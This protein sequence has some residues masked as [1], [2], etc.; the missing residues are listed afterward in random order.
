MIFLSPN[1]QV[2]GKIL[3]FE[4]VSVSLDSA[5]V[6]WE[7]GDGLRSL[8][9]V[10][11]PLRVNYYTVTPVENP[12]TTSLQLTGLS[13]YTSYQVM[14]RGVAGSRDN[15]STV[16]TSSLVF[17]TALQLDTNHM[18][19]VSLKDLVLVLLLL[20]LWLLVIMLFLHRWG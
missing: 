20:L 10:S 7:V 9:I 2:C 17:T 11:S 12:L 1:S 3:S 4:V 5:L 14:L 18:D 15:M 19:T 16:R 8:E 13:P 6:R